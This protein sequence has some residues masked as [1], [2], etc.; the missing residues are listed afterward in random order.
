MKARIPV[1]AFFVLAAGI[2]MYS[3]MTLQEKRGGAQ[4]RQEMESLIK[5]ELL[6]FHNQPFP[7]PQRN[8]FVRQRISDQRNEISPLT[9]GNFQMPD[10]ADSPVQEQTE[11]INVEF[12]LNYIG[13]VKSGDRVV[14]L[15]LLEGESYAVESGDVLESGLTVGEISPDDI[16]IIGSDSISRRIM[17]EGEQR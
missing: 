13:Y 6:A 16:E 4:E 3:G 9:P 5:K 14:A 2:F 15:I 1:V 10:T 12:N 7:A 8:I 17:L 11:A